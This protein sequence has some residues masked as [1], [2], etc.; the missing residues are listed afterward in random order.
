MKKILVKLSERSYQIFIGAKLEDLGRQLAGMKLSKTALVVTNPKV[1]KLYLSRISA[2]LKRA[3]FKVSSCIIGDGEEFK[4]LNTVNKIYGAMLN[5]GLD[6]R[7]PLIAL[8][9][10]VAGDIAGFA[11]ATFMRGVP[12]IQVPTTL[13]AMVDSSVGGKTGVDLKEG[14][15]LIGAF[16][17]PKLVWI[18]IS[19]LKTLPEEH[20]ANGM[21]E[22]IKY[23][24]I[25]DSAFFKFLE[26]N[27]NKMQGQGSRVQGPGKTEKLIGH[28]ISTS[29]KIKADVVSGDER[30]EKGLREILNFGH[31]FGH[32]LETL[33]NYKGI[34]HGQA[35]AIGMNF[36]ASLA[37]KLGMLG[38]SDKARLKNLILLAGLGAC[39]HKRF[40]ANQVISVMKRDKKTRSGKLRFVLP[41]KIGKVT[42]K[43]NIS[44]ELIRKILEK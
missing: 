24:V 26:K 18:D 9:G 25:K 41:V 19:T 5:A 22:V 1:G 40:T 13:L 37:V 28:I 16:Y 29:C 32:A 27:I 23:G 7:S 30:E 21:A 4:T 35:V 6:R 12:L 14:K 36:A 8:G 42:V 31:T 34:L 11:A 10:G 2:G 33:N 20:I 44:S 15:N 38:K 17:Q 39:S 43:S 3:G